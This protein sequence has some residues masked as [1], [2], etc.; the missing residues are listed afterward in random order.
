[1][2]RIRT[3]I[4]IEDTYLEIVM[5]R[6]LLRTKTEAVDLALRHL[7]GQPM[8]REEALAM[9]GAK[10]IGEVPTDVPPRGAA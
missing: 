3:N 4:E 7:A 2:T 10:A 1:M 9:E 6:Y 5:K 8:T